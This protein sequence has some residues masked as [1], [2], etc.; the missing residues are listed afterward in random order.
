ML[1]AVARHRVDNVALQL[2]WTEVGETLGQGFGKA[3]SKHDDE[4][5]SWLAR[6]AQLWTR[7]LASQ[8][9]KDAMLGGNTYGDVWIVRQDIFVWR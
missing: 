6:W 5:P 9:S 8:G 3:R 4:L 7:L 2:L 1:D